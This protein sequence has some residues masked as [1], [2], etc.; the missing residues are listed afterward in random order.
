MVTSAS[1]KSGRSSTVSFTGAPFRLLS[2]ALV[3]LD[4][5]SDGKGAPLHLHEKS[6]VLQ[7][8]GSEWVVNAKRVVNAKEP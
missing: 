5:G 3:C 7:G 1:S 2:V 6:P 4:G 8:E